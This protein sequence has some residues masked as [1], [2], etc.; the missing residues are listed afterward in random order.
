ML[1]VTYFIAVAVAH[2]GLHSAAPNGNIDLTKYA[3]SHW[4]VNSM[5]DD[6]FRFHAALSGRNNLVGKLLIEQGR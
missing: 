6:I 5:L 2:L 3:H 1:S 4:L